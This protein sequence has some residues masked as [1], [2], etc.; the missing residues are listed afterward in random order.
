MMVK[1][2]VSFAKKKKKKAFDKIINCKPLKTGKLS[3]EP[4]QLR[5]LK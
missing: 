3:K 4:S 1:Q 5:I 2:I